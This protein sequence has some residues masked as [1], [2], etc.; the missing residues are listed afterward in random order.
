MFSIWVLETLLNLEA[1]KLGFSLH[2]EL[3]WGLASGFTQ[4]L[5]HG[6]LFLPQSGMQ[7]VKNMFIQNIGTKTWLYCGTVGMGVQF[8]YKCSGLSSTSGALHVSMQ[9]ARAQIRKCS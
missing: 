7:V 8:T 1:F 3:V 9:I 4:L 6:I 2:V 5:F